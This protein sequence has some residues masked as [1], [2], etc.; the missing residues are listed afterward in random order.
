[1]ESLRGRLLIASPA[2]VD[3]NFHRSVVLVVQHDDESAMGIVLNRPSEA[4]VGEAMP[5]LAELVE[6]GDVVHVGGPVQR[7]AVVVLAEWDDA[8]Q[9]ALLVFERVGFMG[10]DADATA[11][12]GATVRARV[13]AGY[14]GWG[15]G[16]LEAEIEEGSWI[17][18]D[19]RA[20]DVFAGRDA[21]ASI[22]R[23]RGPRYR[24]LAL[25][26]EDPSLN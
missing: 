19:A 23:R 3:P 26:P 6:A 12:A 18:V 15:E 24:L 21:F 11:V 4:T 1:M 22:V 10:A 14:A 2:L 13:F 25:M 9:A 16:Q 5:Q 20:D 8:E 7:G 17:V